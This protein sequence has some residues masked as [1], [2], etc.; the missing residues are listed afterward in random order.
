MTLGSCWTSHQT[1]HS[2]DPDGLGMLAVSSAK[3]GG[4]QGSA[5][6][7]PYRWS[8]QEEQGYLQPS[9]CLSSKLLWKKPSEY[10][11]A[12]QGVIVPSGERSPNLFVC[13]LCRKDLITN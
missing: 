7:P 8:H 4:E 13:Q 1:C 10:Q 12:S 2:K 6:E 9:L 3:P 5:E 11:P